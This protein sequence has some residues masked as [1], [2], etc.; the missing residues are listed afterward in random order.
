MFIGSF[1][2]LGFVAHDFRL[3]PYLHTRAAVNTHSSAF[4]FSAWSGDFTY[5]EED[6]VPET[7]SQS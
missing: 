2:E 5:D 4:V 7:G 6:L 3:G 1:A